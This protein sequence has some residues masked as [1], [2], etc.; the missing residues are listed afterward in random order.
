MKRSKLEVIENK[1]AIK[2]VFRAYLR[3][4]NGSIYV[5]LRLKLLMAHSARIVEYISPTEMLCFVIC[6]S[7]CLS[8]ILIRYFSCTLVLERR[9]KF[10]IYGDLNTYTSE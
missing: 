3:Q 4:T 1:N 8:H 2:N 7:V 9:R 5:K 6:L 10:V